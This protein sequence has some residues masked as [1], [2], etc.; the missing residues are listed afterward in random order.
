MGDYQYVFTLET[1]G[2]QLHAAG[3][4]IESGD[5]FLYRTARWN[6]QAW[7]PMGVGTNDEVTVLCS[8]PDGLYAGGAFMGAGDAP[9]WRV[10]HWVA[11][12]SGVGFY[13]VGLALDLHMPNPY[14]PGD[15]IRLSVPAVQRLHVAVYGVDGRRLARLSGD[16][17]ME[18]ALELRW[19]G[20]VHDGRVLPAGLYYLGVSCGI[21]RTHTGFMLVP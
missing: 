12:V 20:R 2:D 21:A 19:D 5:R 8:G 9:S 1:F 6:S 18:G 17:F 11:D 14:R 10:A 15:A 4:F 13:P 7:E 3:N 16:T